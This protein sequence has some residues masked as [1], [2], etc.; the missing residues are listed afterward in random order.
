MGLLGL[1]RGVSAV[2]CPHD[3]PFPFTQAQRVP[4]LFCSA[5]SQSITPLVSLSFPQAEKS[6]LLP[7]R[8]EGKGQQAFKTRSQTEASKR[9]FYC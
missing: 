8:V 4:F 2:W 9:P 7:L 3:L 5:S 1:A 6:V